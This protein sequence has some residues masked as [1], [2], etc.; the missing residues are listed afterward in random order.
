LGTHP[1]WQDRVHQEALAIAP[2]TLEFADF[3]RMEAAKWVLFESLRLYPPL[4]SL[5]RRTVR[6]CEI[7]G[8]GVPSDTPIGLYPIFTHRHHAWWDKPDAFD[9]ER[10]SPSRAEEKRHP[11][12]WVPFGAGVHM[13]LGMSFAEMQVKAIMYELLRRYRVNLPSGYKAPYQ[14]VPIAQ[15]RDGLPINLTRR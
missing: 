5:P 8:V 3:N 2:S 7:H 13:C 14:L 6:D 15:P 12:A 11:Y 9:P 1:E 10:F 4:P